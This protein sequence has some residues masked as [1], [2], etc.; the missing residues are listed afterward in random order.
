[1]AIVDRQPADC[2]YRYQAYISY[3]HKDEKWARWLH[4]RLESYRVPRRLVGQKTQFRVIPRRITPIFRDREELPTAT[5]LGR[6]VQQALEQSACLIVLCSPDAARSHWVNEE[7]L[8]FKR[9]GRSDRIF[10]LIIDG[11]PN[12]A[13]KPEL[14]MEECYSDAL[15]YKLGPDGQLT[16]ELTE[17]IAADLR[18]KKDGK[19]AAKLKLISGILGLELDELRHREHRRY[20]NRLV[21]VTAMSLIAVVVTTG[22]AIKATVAQ[23]E[24]D[25]QRGQAEHLI[26]FM[27]GELHAKLKPIGRLDALEGV[28]DEATRYF[29][30]LS[31]VL[32]QDSLEKRAIAYRQIGEVH[33]AQGHLAAAKK[34]FKKSLADSQLLL[35]LSPDD[36][37]VQFTVGQAQFWVGYVEWEQGNLDEAF[38]HFGSYLTISKALVET[39]S[40]NDKWLRELGYAHTNLGALHSSRGEDVKA[41]EEFQSSIVVKQDLVNRNP[42]ALELQFDLAETTSWAGSA[43][44]A[45]GNL[46]AALERFEQEVAIK[47]KLIVA[48]PRNTLWKRRYS[49]GNRRIG[50]LRLAMGDLD[51]ALAAYRKGMDAIEDLIAVDASN[52]NWQRDFGLLRA[53]LGRISLAHGDIHKALENFRSGI[54]IFEDLLLADATKV[55]WQRD[56]AQGRILVGT[57]LMANGDLD[58]AR[59]EVT[60]AAATLQELLSDYPDDR[61]ASRYLTQSYILD[62]RI[63]SLAGDDRQAQVSWLR[64][65]ELIEPLARGS[66][67]YRLLTH[68]AQ[69]LLYLDRKADATLVVQT[70]TDMGF[71]EPGFVQICESKGLA[72]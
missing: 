66:R 50:E 28:G 31:S 35:E 26:G 11:E 43:L 12:A 1:M 29:D 10:C 23:R 24:A 8:E 36:L 40:D 69:A 48:D 61:E 52:A 54:E 64:S 49:L 41:S 5:D 27:L 37:D 47:S 68:W 6:V 16:D 63:K 57:A 17:P 30:S 15:R 34:D 72:I 45:M 65:L 71:R 60:S 38:D 32:D 42:D 55:R 56:L 4:K 46:D 21:A 59:L 44:S 13:Q 14:E 33:M 51:G 25:F 20:I 70:L 22:L 9:M 58:E 39:E 67:D 7:I 18:P 2:D 62:A 19:N 53:G 3:S